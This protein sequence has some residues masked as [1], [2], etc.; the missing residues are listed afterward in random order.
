MSYNKRKIQEEV[1]KVII[2]AK[3]YDKI[4]IDCTELIN[5]WEDNKKRFIKLFNG[6]L[7]WQYPQKIDITLTDADKEKFFKRYLSELE[8][9]TND[10]DFINYVKSNQKEFYNNVVT[11]PLDVQR[12]RQGDKLSKSFKHFNLSN[13]KKIQDLTSMYQQ[14]EHFSGYFC[15]SVHPLDFLT[16]SENNS[17]W[18][19][20]HTLNGEFASGNLSY[21]SDGSTFVCYLKS[22]KDEQLKVFPEGMLWNN[23]KWRMIGHLNENENCIWFGKQYPLHSEQLLKLTVGED[24]PFISYQEPYQV[25]FNEVL[26]NNKTTYVQDHYVVFN[27]RMYKTADFVIDIGDGLHFNDILY[28]STYEPY[29][30]TRK[31]EAMDYSVANGI[32]DEGEI[33]K[34]L[35]YVHVGN[36]VNTLCECNEYLEDPEEFVCEDCLDEQNY[37]VRY[38]SLCGTRIYYDEEVHYDNNGALL[39]LECANWVEIHSTIY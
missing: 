15:I 24:S 29:I 9:Y 21:M 4:D 14:K 38:C 22:E 31:Q 16:L 8:S 3:K 26:I 34:A 30:S 7:I 11:N 1:E 10:Y 17:N 39:C 18:K 35:F 32:G 20:C 2:Y 25:G 19:S 28:S 27:N 13:L 36:F 12:V 6:E 37:P 5:T 23:K 33:L